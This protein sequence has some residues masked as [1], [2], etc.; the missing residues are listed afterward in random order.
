MAFRSPCGR[1]GYTRSHTHIINMPTCRFKC[2]YFYYLYIYAVSLYCVYEWE[3]TFIEWTYWASGMSFPVK[4]ISNCMQH[5]NK[6]MHTQKERE[7]HFVL[8]C[9]HPSLHRIFTIVVVM[10]FASLISLAFGVRMKREKN[11][12]LAKMLAFFSFLLFSLFF[13][14]HTIRIE[15]VNFL[16]H[17][18]QFNV[19]CTVH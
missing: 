13:F 12:S 14:L 5:N 18:R 8:S 3:F 10:S 17:T 7:E 6:W 1:W 19:Q 11:D 9:V 2:T 16:N 4:I 15:V